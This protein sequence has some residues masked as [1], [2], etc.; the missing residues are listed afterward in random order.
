[1]EQGSHTTSNVTADAA[2]RLLL[3]RTV[4]PACH[5]VVLHN[6]YLTSTRTADLQASC[7]T[8]TDSDALDAIRQA[9]AAWR[10]VPHLGTRLR[11]L[12]QQRGWRGLAVIHAQGRKRPEVP[13]P[14]TVPFEPLALEETNDTLMELAAL[15]QPDATEREIPGMRTV[16]RMMAR[17]GVAIIGLVNPA[18]QA[19]VH[20][21]LGNTALAALN[22]GVAILC[23][24]V[25]VV[26]F[27]ATSGRW[28]VVPGGVIVRRRLWRKVGMRLTR[29]TP[30]DAILVAHPF[31][32]GWHVALLGA[33]GRETQRMTTR[34]LQVLLAA[35]QDPHSPPALEQM[36]DLA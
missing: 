35:W 15:A 21:L 27:W 14:L 33:R 16:R 32:P 2:V 20:G 18:I 1:M 4:A 7:A 26:L 36:S 28:F 3:A 9:A 19:I 5:V 23:I 11:A 30:A 31:P 25:V 34:E 13:P 6:P 17:V 22:G 29:W 12:Q 24:G 8:L 10:D